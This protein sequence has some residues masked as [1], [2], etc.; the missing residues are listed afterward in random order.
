[1]EPFIFGKRNLINI[2]DLRESLRGLV[3][4]MHI[5][6]RL[7]SGGAQFLFV[8][9]KRQAKNV[10][11][12]HAQRIDQH[13]VIERW[14]GG[15]LTNFDTVRSRLKRLDELEQMQEDGTLELYS[16]KMISTLSREMRKIKRNLEGMRRMDKLPDAMIVI[17]PRRE[18]NAISEAGKLQIPVIA[19][20]DTDCDP[21]G[22]DI[23]IPGNDDA[24]RSI[25]LV[26]GSLA[27]AIQEGR[28]QFKTGAG[29][30]LRELYGAPKSD[31]ESIPSK[32]EL[33]KQRRKAG[34]GG[35]KRNARLTR[36]KRK[37]DESSPLQAR[38]SAARVAA[39]DRDDAHA[40]AGVADG[41]EAGSARE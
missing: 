17:D 14:L 26:I 29:L 9:T 39:S 20:L 38:E 15:S 27:N 35:Q 13:F 25:E 41:S 4:A 33:K 8:G 3:R 2:I 37:D 16:K 23:A 32:E 11:R 34:G 1:M 28:K 30:N 5:L 36:T 40:S 19:L 6:E 7:A 24:M 18:H 12:S 21:T 22:V 10:V 31:E